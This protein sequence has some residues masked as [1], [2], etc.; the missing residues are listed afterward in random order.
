MTTTCP[1]CHTASP[2]ITDADLKIGGAWQCVR[3]GH[4]WDAVRMATAA[5]YAVY[6]EARPVAAVRWNA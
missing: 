2:T 6:A 5:A 3:C 4:H 1:L